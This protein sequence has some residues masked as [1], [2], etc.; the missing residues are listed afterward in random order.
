[1][2]G[3]RGPIEMEDYGESVGKWDNGFYTS[4][5]LN[6]LPIDFLIDSGSASTIVSVTTHKQI[7]ES[8]RPI[9]EETNLVLTGV[10]GSRL[11]TKSLAM[12]EFSFKDQNIKHPTIICDIQQPAI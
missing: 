1:M 9:V 10:E 11:Y 4:G 8:S 6:G 2:T 5:Y 7:P 3:N 12:Y